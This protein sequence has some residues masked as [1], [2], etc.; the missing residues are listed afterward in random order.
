MA[1][2]ALAAID[3]AVAEVVN[4]QRVTWFDRLPADAQDTLAAAREKFY[5]GGYG[6]LKRT[7]L[8]RILI[9]HAAKQGWKTPKLKGMCEWLAKNG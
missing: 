4:A 6:T 2:S 3:A 9:E 8:C 1:R 5:S 7:T